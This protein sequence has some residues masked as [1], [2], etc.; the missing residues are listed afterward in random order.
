[1]FNV[2]GFVAM[3][4]EMGSELEL[5]KASLEGD[6]GA[7]EGI[8]KK[9]Q[10]FVCAITVSA[11]GDVEK[12]EELAQETFIHA[13]K[14]LGQLKELSKF[15]S[16]IG[17]IARNRIRDSFKSQRRDILESKAG[18]SEQSDCDRAS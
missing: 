2:K 14:D 8:V 18:Y 16:W 6:V 7:F 4:T 3:S 13:W 1:M 11:T 12:S 5:L 10:S 9:Y 17:S 15:R